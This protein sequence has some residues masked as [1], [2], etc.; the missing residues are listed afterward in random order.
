MTPQR[1][2]IFKALHGR[3]DHPTAEDVFTVVSA[4]MPTISRRTV[5]Q[6]L[7]DLA[8]MGEIVELDLGT[9]AARFDPTVNTHH[10][11]VCVRCGAVRDTH[12]D[13][14]GISL[15]AGED[16]GF[17]VASTEIVFRGMCSECALSE[18]ADTQDG[19]SRTGTAVRVG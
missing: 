5:Y 4:E 12:A 18:S 3:V 2:C 1:Q 17:T 14:A 15:P 13:F 7:H 10:H 6:T 9:G 11:L 8:D 19:C 16:H